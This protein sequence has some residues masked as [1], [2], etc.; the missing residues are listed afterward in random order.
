MKLD[1]FLRNSIFGGLSLVLFVTP[2]IIANW[3]FFPY[4]TGKGFFFR[5][6]VE[7]CFALWII[8]VARDR[9]Y[10]PKKSQVLYAVLAFVTVLIFSTA[11][12]VNPYRS[13]WSNFERMEGLVS[14]LHLF[15]YF[16]MLVSLMGA[17]PRE[18]RRRQWYVVLYTSVAASSGMT[19]YG[20][21]QLFDRSLISGQSGARVDGT[22]GNAA[23]MAVYLLLHIFLI[24]YLLFKHYHRKW[25][26]WG[27]GVAVFLEIII[28]AL[29]QTRGAFYGTI[30]GILFA[31]VIIAIHKGGRWRMGTIVVIL[32]GAVTFG[33]LYSLRGTTAIKSNDTLNRLLSVSLTDRTVASRLTIWSMAVE[34][35]TEHPVLGW[36]LDNFNLIFNKYYKSSLFNQEQW[37]DRAHNVFFDWLS[38]AGILGLLTYLALFVVALLVIWKRKEGGI[39]ER[40]VLSGLLLAYF[41][42]N[43]FVFDNLL[44]SIIFFTLLAYLAGFDAEHLSAQ[45]ANSERSERRDSHE[46]ELRST[47]HEGKTDPTLR[48]ALAT[49]A[50]A[51]M[52]P[53]IYLVTIK[54]YRAGITLINAITPCPKDKIARQTLPDGKT[55]L[56]CSESRQAGAE[57]SLAAFNALFAAHT[58]ADTEGREQLMSMA[59]QTGGNTQVQEATREA[60]LR[61]AEAEMQK[62]LAA[63]PND[64]RYHLFMGMFYRAVGQF[65]AAVRELTEAVRLTPAKPSM[66]ANLGSLY[67]EHKD[68]AKAIEIFKVAFEFDTRNQEVGRLLADAYVQSG[69]RARAVELIRQMITA[70]PGYAGP[71]EAYIEQIQA[72]K[73]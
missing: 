12:S 50:C 44:S 18:E 43:F 20:L 34:G 17:V 48:Y 68:T 30:I 56:V 47:N 24:L 67:L 46:S 37:F 45:S 57:R 63:T 72:K 6:I 40:A 2:F 61:L 9:K 54:P 29:T 71:G 53:A 23:Y 26:A 33:G 13:F 22:F 3:L 69:D 19:L 42:H 38:A 58:F 5:L 73:K 70:D 28:L 65:D 14:Y 49:V 10:W 41:I 55:Q 64:A 66:L 62:Q 21:M 59:L 16:I 8:L 15:A 1:T 52:I 35:V 36:G 25:L 27:L 39:G 60:F 51:L 11:L 31:L 32:L 4:I 7:I